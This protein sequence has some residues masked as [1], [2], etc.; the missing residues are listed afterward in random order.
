MDAVTAIAVLMFA[1]AGTF[2]AWCAVSF[3]RWY[4]AGP[5]SRMATRTTVKPFDDDRSSQ[6]N[7]K[8][9]MRS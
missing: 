4:K 5:P 2:L 9:M 6:R 8:R 1:G 7:F 3:Y